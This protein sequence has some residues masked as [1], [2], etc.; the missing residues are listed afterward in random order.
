MNLKK[1]AG[2]NNKHRVTL[3]A[4]STCGWCRRTKELLNEHNIEYDYID[5]DLCIGEEREEVLNAVRQINPR[6]SFPTLQIDG[7]V[8]V[9]F[10]E[11][12]IKE[13]LEI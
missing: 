5:V 2:S 3:Y 10:D 9:G 7:Q 12:R 1:V 11:E 6:V 13:L 4:L 8:V